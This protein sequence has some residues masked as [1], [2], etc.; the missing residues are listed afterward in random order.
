M[1][2]LPKSGALHYSFG[3]HLVRQQ[4]LIKAI[5]YFEKS[6]K[7]TPSNSQYA[8]TYILA[9]D[10]LGNSRNALAQLKALIVS[11][12]DKTQLKELGLYLSQKLQ[13][14]ADYDWFIKF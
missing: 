9:H 14:K 7:L 4:Q 6:M 1:K 10:G 2:K 11:Y 8:Y 13:S 3:L 5:K 12:Q